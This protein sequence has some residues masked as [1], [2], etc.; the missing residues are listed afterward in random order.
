MLTG[1]STNRTNND[2]DIKPYVNA[3]ISVNLTEGQTF[4]LT[5]PCPNCRTVVPVNVT[6][7]YTYLDVDDPDIETYVTRI[8]RRKILSCD[9]TNCLNQLNLVGIGEIENSGEYYITISEVFSD[10]FLVRSTFIIRVY[11]NE[12]F[13]SLILVKDTDTNEVVAGHLE[14][15]LLYRFT[16]SSK[17]YP[18]PDL[19]M[20]WYSLCDTSGELI[21]VTI[22]NFTV[23]TGTFK[24]ILYF[25]STPLLYGALRCTANENLIEYQIIATDI[26]RNPV[27]S[28]SGIRMTSIPQ[29]IGQTV[30][31]NNL[32]LTIFLHNTLDSVRCNWEDITD[33]EITTSGP[34]IFKAVR[35]NSS[36]TCFKFSYQ[37]AKIYINDGLEIKSISYSVYST[38]FA[39]QINNVSRF[40]N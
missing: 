7:Y 3:V 26:P 16:C 27:S 31:A 39:I 13:P 2:F 15:N 28:I 32:T 24:R 36:L 4:N 20:N 6:W 38:K 33:S 34:M 35:E 40:S 37:P 10:V 14:N 18:Y 30:F 19:R 12:L 25:E 9:S 22:N 5:V 29:A 8:V 11:S 21:N 1:T 17:S 23:I